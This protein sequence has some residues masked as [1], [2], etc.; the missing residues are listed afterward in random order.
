[1]NDWLKLGALWLLLA[2]LLWHDY[3]L[4]RDPEG[5]WHDYLQR[6]KQ[7]RWSDAEETLW[8]RSAPRPR[9]TPDPLDIQLQRFFMGSITIVMLVYLCYLIFDGQ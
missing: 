1:M 8:E 2:T 9:P 7:R 3:R 4:W 6:P 5:Y